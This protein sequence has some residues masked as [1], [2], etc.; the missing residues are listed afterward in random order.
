MQ[1]EGEREREEV[2]EEGGRK[3]ERQTYLAPF[4]K[5]TN[6]RRK[7]DFTNLVIEIVEKGRLIF[8]VHCNEID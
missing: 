5:L 1:E 6:L 3:R 8:E 2:E 7:F 4:K